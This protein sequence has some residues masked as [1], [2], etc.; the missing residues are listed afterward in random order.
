MIPAARWFERL[1]A[2][3]TLAVWTLF[4]FVNGLGLRWNRSP[5][6]PIGLWQKTHEP[7]HRGSYVTL[8][9]PIKQ[10]AGVPGDFVQY[11]PLGVKV[12]GKLWPNSAPIGPNHVPFGTIILIPGEYLLM[13][14]NP[15]SFD[16]RYFGWTPATMINGTMKPLFV[17]E[18]RK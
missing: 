12:N 1:F 3:A 16:A 4:A 11:T 6:V 8:D 5:S 18:V 2:A 10:I 9:E 7:I 17:N 14:N 13:G 15:L